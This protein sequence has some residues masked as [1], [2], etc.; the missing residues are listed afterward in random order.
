[1]ECRA[2]NLSTIN[3]IAYQTFILILSV[4]FK[5]AQDANSFQPRGNDAVGSRLFTAKDGG[6]TLL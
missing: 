1:M 3:S 2:D 6:K 5:T 4:L